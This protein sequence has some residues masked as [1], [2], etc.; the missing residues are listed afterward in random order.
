MNNSAMLANNK[1]GIPMIDK[2]Y[3]QT[4]ETIWDF[5]CEIGKSKDVF[6]CRSGMEI[7]EYITYFLP[8]E[9]K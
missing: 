1:K 8:P 7:D 9:K 4:N 6:S 5:L 2:F 3:I